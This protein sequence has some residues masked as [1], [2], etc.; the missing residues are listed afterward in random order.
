MRS[1]VLTVFVLSTCA[2]EAQPQ[3]PFED[4]AGWQISDQGARQMPYLNRPSLYLQNGVALSPNDAF[5]DGTIDFDVAIHGQAGFAGV[6]FRAASDEDYELIYLRTH[7][8]RQWDALQYTPVF[9]ANESWQLY[10]GDGYSGVAELP[11]NRWVHVRVVVEEFTARVFVDNAAAPQLTVSDLKRPWSAGRAG[12]WGRFGAANF[13]NFRVTRR[14]RP[15]PVTRSAVP[16]AGVVTHWA[17]SPPFAVSSV[18]TDRVPDNINWE[19]V[20]SE[21]TGTLN[22]GRYRT[23]LPSR[24][25]LNEDRRSTVFA[26]AILRVAEGRL[27]KLSFGYSDDVTIFLDGVPLFTGRAGYLSRDGSFLGT[28]TLS[29]DTLY[30]SLTAGRH[31]LV[32]AVSEAFGGWGLAAKFEPG[33]AVS[34]ERY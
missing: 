23:L 3:V 28:M 9:N 8:S 11:S 2:L 13:S 7:R 27:V 4:F 33:N 12:L 10:S 19:R 5:A 18:P 21:P 16:D 31:E 14:I 30:V 17:I 22:I 34:T 6:I 24:A 15:A 25:G 32:L 26:K 29:A 1:I 20:E